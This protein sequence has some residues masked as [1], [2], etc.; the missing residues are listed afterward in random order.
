MNEHTHTYTHTEQ[1]MRNG[2]EPGRLLPSKKYPC[3]HKRDLCRQH[4]SIRCLRNIIHWNLI[5]TFILRNVMWFLLQLID[6]NIH[7]SN[8]VTSLAGSGWETY[9]F[10]FNFERFSFQPW[11]RL[12]TT[13]YNY[14]VV[15]NFFWMFVEGCYLHTAIVMTYSTDKLRKWVFLF[16][17]WCECNRV[18][19]TLWTL[20]SPLVYDGKTHRVHRLVRWRHFCFSSWWM[21]SVSVYRHLNQQHF[22]P[23]CVYKS[24]F[25]YVFC[26]IM[27]IYYIT[28]DERR[29]RGKD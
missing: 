27:L 18:D 3:E 21:E 13:I 22:S 4:R 26:G 15:T 11:C 23:A 16:I 5:T 25:D 28:T 24:K 10:V 17:G 2:R 12:I 7:E 19:R 9:C 29:E 8:E 20:R 1:R 14:F 6:H